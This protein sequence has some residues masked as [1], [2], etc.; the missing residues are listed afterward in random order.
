M[1][2]PALESHFYYQKKNYIL[3]NAI[4]SVHVSRLYSFY[5]ITFQDRVITLLKV[6]ILFKKVILLIYVIRVHF[7]FNYITFSGQE[8]TFMRKKYIIKNK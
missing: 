7:L 5:Y 8:N 1:T 4:L 2:F 6:Y 3:K